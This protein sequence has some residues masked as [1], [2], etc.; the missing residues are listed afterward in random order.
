MSPGLLSLSTRTVQ[1]LALLFV[2]ESDRKSEK[3]DANIPSLPLNGTAKEHG[4]RLSFAFSAAVAVLIIACPCA[5]G[6]ATPMAVMV[7]VG[8]GAQLGILVRDAAVLEELEKISVVAFDKTGTL[9]EGNPTVVE[10]VAFKPFSQ[11]E[12]LQLAAAVESLSEYPLERAIVRAAGNQ[13]L[14]K[15]TAFEATVGSGVRAEVDSRVVY[16]GKSSSDEGPENVSSAAANR[17]R[18]EGKTAVVVLIDNQPA[19]LI[20]IADTLKRNS[21]DAVKRLHDLKIRSVML[22]GDNKVT[23]R[24]IAEAAGIDDVIAEVSPEQE[25]EEIATRANSS[26]TL[27]IRVGNVVFRRAN[28]YTCLLPLNLVLFR[29]CCRHQHDC[30]QHRR[31]HLLLVASECKYIGRADRQLPARPLDLRFCDENLTRSGRKQV[32]LELH[33][34]NLMVGGSNTQGCV[35][36]SRIQNGSNCA[37]VEVA[38]LLCQARREWQPNFNNALPNCG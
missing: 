23:A 19:G 29:M 18:R 31:N 27:P 11:S 20:A 4:P 30:G 7:G 10:T 32:Y 13:A 5:L 26:T 34:E 28:D 16:V 17:W 15:A 33:R 14:P 3:R 35:T 24:S 37:G 1:T 25:A 38:V 21:A 9:T 6:L 36:A 2:S 8:R 12:V 22:T